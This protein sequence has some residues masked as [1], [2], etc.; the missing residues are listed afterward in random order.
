MAFKQTVREEQGG[1]LKILV[2][3]GR[4]DSTEGDEEDEGKEN[5]GGKDKGDQ[6]SFVSQAES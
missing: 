1:L 4:K 3:A 2:T 5:E 6:V